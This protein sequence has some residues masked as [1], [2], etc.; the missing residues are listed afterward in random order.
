MRDR[1]LTPDMVPVIKLARMLKIPYSWISAYYAG[2]NF[3]R[4]AD[5]MKGRRFP[6][7]PPATELPPDFP[8][9]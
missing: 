6:N 9:A 4:I 7:I 2:L 8:R 3:G 5:V 1:V